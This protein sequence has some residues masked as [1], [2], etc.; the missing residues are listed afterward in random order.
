MSK[1]LVVEDVPE[2]VQLVTMYME[3]AGF[4]CSACETAE[5]ALEELQKGYAPDLV[6]LDLTLPGMRGLDFL[7]KFRAA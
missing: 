3:K 6:L 2:M 1:I 7:K 5:M 4:T